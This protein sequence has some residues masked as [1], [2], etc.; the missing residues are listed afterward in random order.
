[1]AENHTTG[2]KSHRGYIMSHEGYIMSHRGSILGGTWAILLARG[3]S[4]PTS[5]I[6]KKTCSILY[7][8]YRRKRP[9]MDQDSR[10]SAATTIIHRKT[11]RN[12]KVKFQKH[13]DTCAWT[14]NKKILN[15]RKS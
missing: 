5:E 6:Y 1:M 15:S 3:P 11:Q 8:F 14:P 10:E 12:E 4:K 7:M 2:V 9:A 13:N